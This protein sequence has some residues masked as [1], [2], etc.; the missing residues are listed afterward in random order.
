MTIDLELNNYSYEKFKID[1]SILHNI[2]G[3]LFPFD[4]NLKSIAVNLSGGADSALGTAIL[5]TLIKKYNTNTKITVITNIRGWQYRPWQA[6]I[7]L[8]VY[9]KLNE[10]FPEI[11]F[12]RL[13]NFIPPELETSE[14]GEI[15]QLGSTGDKVITSSFNNYAKYTNNL[16]KVYA[17]VTNNP[18]DEEMPHNK[19]LL[20][21]YW[22]KEKV[23]E[24]FEHSQHQI[25]NACV[26]ISGDHYHITP[27]ILLKKDFVMAQY[28]K[29]D[30]IDLLDTTRS[31]EGDVRLVDRKKDNWEYTFVDYK[32]YKHKVTRL[33]TCAE[34][35]KDPNNGCYWCA[36]RTWAWNKVKKD[37]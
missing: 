17:F 5:C 6:P 35:I 16:E 1:K 15:K 3:A 33:T 19:K 30:W 37:V 23:D 24:Y 21:R 29:N 2:D 20:D 10:M 27:W 32:E 34:N 18:T 22:S 26:Q 4:K 28:I 25:G 9:N 12:D 13:V 31:C 11:Q 7:A 14:I 36:E 8:D